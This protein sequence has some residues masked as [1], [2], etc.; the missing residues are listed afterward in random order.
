[1]PPQQCR[2]AAAW[3]E[4]T[5][6]RP[7]ERRQGRGDTTLLMISRAMF[8]REECVLPKLGGKSHANICLVSGRIAEAAPTRRCRRR[9]RDSRHRLRLG[10]V[11]AWELCEDVGGQHRK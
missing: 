1:M 2:G 10:R 8:G 3:A 7:I 6:D 9:R 11:D 4:W 5:I